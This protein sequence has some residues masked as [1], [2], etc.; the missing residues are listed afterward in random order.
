MRFSDLIGQSKAKSAFTGMVRDNRVPHA[1]L[2]K[3]RPGI[4]K[5]GF[6]TALAQYMNC[7][8]PGTED[9]CGVCSSCSKIGKGIHPDVRYILPI[10]SNKIGG[11][12]PLSDDYYPKF[13]EH[14]FTN[15][16][17]SFNEWIT[18]MAG[19]N[20][21]VGIRINEVRDLKRKITLKAFEGPYKIVIIW[22]SE[23]INTE[24]A[25]AML[26][27]LEEPPEKTIIIMTVSDTTHLLTTINS[28]CQRIQ[29]HRVPDAEMA[30]YLQEKHQFSEERAIQVSQ[31][32]D[33]SMARAIELIH[34]SNRS[35]SE[36]YMTWL[37]LCL[38]GNFAEIHAWVELVSKENKEFQKLFMSYALQKVRDSLLFSFQADSISASTAEERDFQKKF[39]RFINLH[40]IEELSRLIDDSLFYISRNA[41]TQMVLSVLSLRVHSLLTGKVL[42]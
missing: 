19:E 25:N 39:S 3:G 28:R 32:A 13:R 30:V 15:P 29:M 6:A 38:K 33:G 1:I 42:I 41:N 27:L 18:L 23:K 8:N 36:L 12:S 34:E 17:F 5:L 40:G 35:L 31:L 4:G 11:K 22:N 7:E 21:Q 24:A 2:L 26:K 37:R 16:Y 9:S 14:F 20:K 10:I